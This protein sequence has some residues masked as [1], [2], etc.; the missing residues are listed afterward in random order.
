MERFNST[1]VD[2]KCVFLEILETIAHKNKKVLKTMHQQESN[3]D[4]L[5]TFLKKE[6]Q[7]LII[8]VAIEGILYLTPSQAR[9]K[10][11]YPLKRCPIVI[12][13]FFCS[14]II[15]QSLSTGLESKLHL[16]PVSK[17]RKFH[18]LASCFRG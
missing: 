7:V 2:E 8:P 1:V 18:T 15:T 11:L 4:V 3:K 14:I 10:F 5:K 16:L 17:M 13:H 6:F 12:Y 9:G